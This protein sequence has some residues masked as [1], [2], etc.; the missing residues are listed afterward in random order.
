MQIS[1]L[2]TEAAHQALTAAY[3]RCDWPTAVSVVALPNTASARVVEPLGARLD[4]TVV[5]RYGTATVYRHASLADLTGPI[6][7]VE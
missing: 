2:E 6:S 5:N 3:Q 4:G 7:H 1:V